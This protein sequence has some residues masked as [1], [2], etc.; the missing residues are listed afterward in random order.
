M[1]SPKRFT[2]RRVDLRRVAHKAQF[3]IGRIAGDQA[4]I[5]ARQAHGLAALGID[6]LHDALVDAARE[7]HF[8][9]LDRGGIGHALAVHEFRRDAELFQ[10]LVDHRSAA[11]D[12]HRVHAHLP[13]QDDIAGEARHRLVVAHGVAAELDDDD[14]LVEALQVGERLAQGAGGGDVV[15]GHGLF[16]HVRIRVVGFQ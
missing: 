1:S 13:Q 16:L 6:R 15:A 10:H 7:D 3:G 14:R 9:H 2:A 8:D 5:L 12:D 11:M 4:R